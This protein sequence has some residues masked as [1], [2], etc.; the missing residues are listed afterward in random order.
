[1]LYCLDFLKNYGLKTKNE[2]FQMKYS[3]TLVPVRLNTY[4]ILETKSYN[5]GLLSY[6]E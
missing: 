2:A 1:M 4:C 5:L 3:F 6:S